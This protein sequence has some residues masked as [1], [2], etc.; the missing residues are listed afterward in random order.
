MRARSS[1]CRVASRTPLPGS[2]APVTP[3]LAD[4]PRPAR[5]ALAPALQAAVR[6]LDGPPLRAAFATRAL[7]A[8]LRL[9]ETLPEKDLSVA[10]SAQSDAGTVLLGL[11]ARPSVAALNDPL[12]AARVRGVAAR[13]ELLAQEGGLLRGED[14]AKLLHVSRQAVD[15]RRIQGKLLGLEL[16]RRGFLYPAWQL[17]ESGTLSGL[18]RVLVSLRDK[19]VSPLAQV[20]FF[21]SGS[22]RLR[23]QRPLDRLREGDIDAVMRDAAAYLE[24]GAG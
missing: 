6:V 9:A 23:G 17:G 2:S 5:S 3:G 14:V 24:H 4:P 21:L 16:G 11:L 15:R 19:E 12:F 1:Q 7:N 8:L 13:D 20:R 22:S 10:V 18:E